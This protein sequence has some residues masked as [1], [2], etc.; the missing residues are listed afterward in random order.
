MSMKVPPFIWNPEAEVKSGMGEAEERRHVTGLK[1][2]A[3][4]LPSSVL[5]TAL[6]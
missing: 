6:I 3:L 1:G 4:L 5:K 2:S